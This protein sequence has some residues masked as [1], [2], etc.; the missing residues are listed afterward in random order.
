MSMN[1][2]MIGKLLE[3]Q[4]SEIT[5]HHIYRKIA[6]SMKPGKNRETIERIARDEMRH[7]E[8]WRS[9]TG[10]DVRPDLLKLWFYYLISLV[11]GFTFA[12]KLMEQ[13][14]DDAQ[15]E[16][17]RIGTQVPEAGAILEDETSHEEA[18][19]RLLEE[20]RIRY[21]GSMVLGLNDALV[22]LTGALAGLTLALQ[23]AHLIALTG[24]ITGI[25]AAMSMAASEYL[26]TKAEE[27]SKNPVRAS[28]YT[29]IAYIVTVLVLITPYLILPNYYVSLGVTLIL[30]VLI[31]AFFTYYLSVVKDVPFKSRF[32]EMA[33]LS[34][35]IAFISFLVGFAL[36]TV[37]GVEV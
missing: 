33:G 24:S 2:A 8:I 36:R 13:G 20:E 3:Y 5:E 34:L 31:I 22:E 21:T 15:S 37:F 18:L 4:R 29:G 12:I 7:Y 19:I 17:R 1:G 16:Y 14:E 26:S 6:S 11:L 23:D 28:V 9:Y 10:R 32:F 35:G 27:T 30:A 25:A